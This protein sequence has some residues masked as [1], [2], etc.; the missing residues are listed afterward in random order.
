MQ[1]GFHADVLSVSLYVQPTA[2]QP[3]LYSVDVESKQNFFVFLGFFVSSRGRLTKYKVLFPEKHVDLPLALKHEIQ[4]RHF[5]HRSP[6]S[7]AATGMQTN[8]AAA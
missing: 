3:H 8:G 5:S 2:S 7:A 6:I 1:D 4:Y